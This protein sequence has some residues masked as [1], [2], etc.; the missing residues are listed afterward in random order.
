MA[1]VPQ[2]CG[3]SI[4]V[5]EFLIYAD[6]RTMPNRPGASR[7]TVSEFAVMSPDA[8]QGADTRRTRIAGQLE[9]QS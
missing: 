8:L 9:W 5:Y 3:L 4:A 6:R 2:S 7:C 1:R